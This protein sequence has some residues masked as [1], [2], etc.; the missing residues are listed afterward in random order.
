[1]ITYFASNVKVSDWTTEIPHE[2]IFVAEVPRLRRFSDFERPEFLQI[3]LHEPHDFFAWGIC[4]WTAEI[5]YACSELAS[6]NYAK[7]ISVESSLSGDMAVASGGSELRSNERE[8]RA[9]P[10]PKNFSWGISNWTYGRTRIAGIILSAPILGT[11]CASIK[12]VVSSQ[13][14]KDLGI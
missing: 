10:L 6:Q 5:P 11:G 12:S 14:Q 1:M 8:A 7:I 13:L 2:R 9:T 3:R 4:D